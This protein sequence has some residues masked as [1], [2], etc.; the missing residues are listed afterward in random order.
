MK[1]H[2]SFVMKVALYCSIALMAGCTS[3]KLVDIWSDPSFQPPSLNKMLVLSVSKNPVQRRTWE[4]A[5]S[6]ELAK[7][8]VTVTPSY[9]LFPD[10]VPDTNQIIQIMQSNGF[11][12]ILVYRRLL[13]ETKTKYKQGFGMSENNTVYDRFS[14][15][16]VASYF[17]DVDYAAHVDSQKVDMRAI[18]V[19]TTKDEGQII[20]SAT[21]ETPEPNS[22]QEVRP[23]IVK[24]V[25]SDLTKRRMIASKR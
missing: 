10:A 16:F 21:S 13:P 9:L 20:W 11:D 2:K 12:G 1:R 4:D 24:L 25:M 8:N 23:E 18:D 22:V 15:R 17:R 3:S 6:V 5:F 19:W 7:H 14:R